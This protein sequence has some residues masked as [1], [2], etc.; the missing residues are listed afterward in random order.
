MGVAL[1]AGRLADGEPDTL[2]AIA[3]LMFSTNLEVRPD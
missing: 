1:E 3:T 2:D